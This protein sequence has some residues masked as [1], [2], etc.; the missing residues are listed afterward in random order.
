MGPEFLRWERT[1]GDG[2][3]SRRAGAAVSMF[4]ARAACC[5]T[6]AGGSG[7]AAATNG[8]GTGEPGA[9]ADGAGRGMVGR[10]PSTRLQHEDGAGRHAKSEDGMQRH[11]LVDAQHEAAS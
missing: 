11:R 3:W 8:G 6:R 7:A 1:R 2:G 9:G 5:A 10:W 4:L